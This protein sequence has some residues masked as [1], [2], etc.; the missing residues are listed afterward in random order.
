M[1]IGIGTPKKKSR[2]ERPITSSLEQFCSYPWQRLPLRIVPKIVGFEWIP[3]RLAEWGAK[4][5]AKDRTWWRRTAGG[6]CYLNEQ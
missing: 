4:A 2:I 3:L 5:A 6:Y 1:M